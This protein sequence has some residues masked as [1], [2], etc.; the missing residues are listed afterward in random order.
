MGGSRHPDIWPQPEAADLKVLVVDDHEANLRIMHILLAEFGCRAV[1]AACGEEAVEHAEA[2]PFDLIVMDLNMPGMDGD[3]ATR[4]IRESGAS[5][6]AFVVRWTTEFVRFG[7]GL[8]DSA[9]P[10]PMTAP[11]LGDILS[12]A[13][14]RAANQSDPRRAETA[15]PEHSAKRQP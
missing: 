11:A 3:E 5:K 6:G 2:Q 10:K 14:R 4:L 15:A 8:Y 1:L 12:E 9:A 13:V 7:P